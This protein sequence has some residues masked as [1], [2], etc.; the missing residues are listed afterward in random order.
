MASSDKVYFAA[1]P[2][3]ETIG[4]IMKRAESWFQNLRTN[5]YLDKL[6]SMWAAYHG[7]Y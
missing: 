5:G 1:K 4:V 6:T 3:E 7:A 2:A